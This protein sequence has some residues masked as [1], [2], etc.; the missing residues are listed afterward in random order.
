MTGN[1]CQWVVIHG[2]P[3]S[4]ATIVGPFDD[5]ESASAYQKKMTLI[6]QKEGESAWGSYAIMGINSPE[7]EG[8]PSKVEGCCC[9]YHKA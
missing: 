9:A 6:N 4:T 5:W 2:S 8:L 7:A 3:V 1:S